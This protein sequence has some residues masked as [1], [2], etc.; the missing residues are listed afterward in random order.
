LG[1]RPKEQQ[2]Q[3]IKKALEILRPYLPEKP[4]IR[5]PGFR[6]LPFSEGIVKKL[7][8]GG[9]AYQGFIKIFQSGEI[10]STLDTHLTFDKY[11]NPIGLLW[12]KL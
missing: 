2:E 9:I 3:D 6:V 1:W 12:H 10:I 4:L 7:G 11:E 8:F 5:F